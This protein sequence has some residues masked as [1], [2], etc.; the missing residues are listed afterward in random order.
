[1]I[2]PKSLTAEQQL[3][4]DFAINGGDFALTQ[5]G[6][7]TGKSYTMRAITQH[8][9]APA[10]RCMVTVVIFKH[11]LLLPF[12]EAG[13]RTY[14]N[15]KFF[16][17]LLN[18]DYFTYIHLQNQMGYIKCPR[19]LLAFMLALL[20]RAV[21]ECTAELLLPNYEHL[22]IF[23]EYTI[24]PTPFLIVLILFLKKRNIRFLF[25]GD[26][27]QH[28]PINK[29]PLIQ[30]TPFEVIRLFEPTTIFYLSENKR[31]PDPK[32]AQIIE[33]VA[34]FPDSDSKLT[35]LHFLILSLVF[36]NKA[37]NFPGL[38][39]I[40]IASWHR[41]FV[42]LFQSTPEIT[43][44]PYFIAKKRPQNVKKKQKLTG[45]LVSAEL[46][47]QLGW[48]E[49]FDNMFDLLFLSER[50]EKEKKF[51]PS[52]PLIKGNPYYIEDCRYESSIGI[53]LDFDL[54]QNWIKVQDSRGGI[55]KLTRSHNN[56][57]IFQQ[58]RETL[59]QGHGSGSFVF[60]FPIYPAFLMTTHRAQGCTV[61]RDVDLHMSHSNVRGMYVA[62]SR[63][64]NPQSI[65]SIQFP[66]KERYLGS[67]ALYCSELE[68][69]DFEINAR[70][71]QDVSDRVNNGQFVFYEFN[72]DHA[73]LIQS[74]YRTSTKADRKIIK[75]QLISKINQSRIP[76]RYTKKIKDQ[77]VQFEFMEKACLWS[78]LN[79]REN[80]KKTPLRELI[81]FA[82]TMYRSFDLFLFASYLSDVIYPGSEFESTFV[83]NSLTKFMYNPM[84]SKHG[85]PFSMTQN[86]PSYMND[87]SSCKYQQ[88]IERFLKAPF[89]SLKN[90]FSAIQR[91]WFLREI[92]ETL[93]NAK[94]DDELKGPRIES[95]RSTS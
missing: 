33:F 49:Q 19:T 81:P 24:I 9:S 90:K 35:E 45:R 92:Q 41:E 48:P 76:C 85:N 29:S 87:E 65:K 66:K 16:M 23:D 61:G 93:Y 43:L 69:P 75:N 63:V 37:F 56:D 54:D 2:D 34:R 59:V 50:V 52:L 4:F 86:T 7:G 21:D 94:L 27:R 31:C 57:V 20:S 17:E 89:P 32:Y 38:S 82:A 8:L 6:P 91:L 79:S 22:F 95:S 84:H 18:V 62:L 47:K 10:H 30:C 68:D 60:N 67:I 40:Q 13:A 36:Q 46:R 28:G 5:A 72:S 3:I 39:N 11:M 55:R 15:A 51:L 44:S 78:G 25:V 14:T 74:F 42:A 53:L 58:H 80:E 71:L 26:L 70:Y 1:M 83:E 12:K 77:S 73:E 88:R 64:T